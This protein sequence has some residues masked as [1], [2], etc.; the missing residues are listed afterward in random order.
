ML[1]KQCRGNNWKFPRWVVPHFLLVYTPGLERM[2]SIFPYFLWT[3]AE[4]RVEFEIP[5]ELSEEPPREV[6]IMH[7]DE[8]SQRDSSHVDRSFRSPLPLTMLPPITLT[9][10]LPLD[11]PLCRPRLSPGFVRVMV[12]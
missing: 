11:Y 1:V 2:K 7:P 9:L 6:M 12:S 3:T 10:T 5:L 8:Q 4:G